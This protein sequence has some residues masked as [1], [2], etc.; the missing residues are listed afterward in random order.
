M[1]GLVNLRIHECLNWLEALGTGMECE[2][3]NSFCKQT[4]K[5]ASSAT[6]VGFKITILTKVK[7]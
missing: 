7:F 3:F 4:K 1:G 2:R 6:M 5:T